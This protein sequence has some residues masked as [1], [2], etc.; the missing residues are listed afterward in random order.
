MRFDSAGENRFPAQI[1]NL[2]ESLENLAGGV[3]I[4][5]PKFSASPE[6]QFRCETSDV[7]YFLTRSRHSRFSGQRGLRTRVDTQIGGGMR[8]ATFSKRR[9]VCNS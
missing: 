9:T 6:N 2:A 8:V 7:V 3:S 5:K 4:S 1:Q